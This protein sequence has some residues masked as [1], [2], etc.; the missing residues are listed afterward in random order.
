MCSGLKE[1]RTRQF[2]S[3]SFRP[4]WPGMTK[5]SVKMKTKVC[6]SGSW[7]ITR[8]HFVGRG[9][10]GGGSLGTDLYLTNGFPISKPKMKG[11]AQMHLQCVFLLGWIKHDAH[12]SLNL[13]SISS[14]LEG[15]WW[16]VRWCHTGRGGE[17]DREKE[18]L[19]TEQTSAF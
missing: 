6:F 1:P 10:V 15:R 9:G 5:S 3:V 18:E 19:Q 8:R 7:K 2:S 16:L 13:V 11:D 4:A 14:G 12:V 17:K